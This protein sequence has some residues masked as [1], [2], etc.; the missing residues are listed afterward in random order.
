MNITIVNRVFRGS[1]AMPVDLKSICDSD[2]LKLGATEN[3]HVF[4]C[5]PKMLRIRRLP[6]GATVLLFNSGR[7]R[8][9][10]GAIE[11]VEAAQEWMEKLFPNF[12]ME[13]L[14]FLQTQ[15]CKFEVPFQCAN[16]V[17]KKY[18]DLIF[19]EPEI[20]T[21]AMKLI[22]WS[23]VHVNLFFSG[24][25]MIL[26]RKSYERAFE[27]KAWLLQILKEPVL[28]LLIVAAESAPAS[29]SSSYNDPLCMAI[30]ELVSML[31]HTHRKLGVGYF[32]SFPRKLIF[33]W[34]HRINSM[35]EKDTLIP[36]LCQ[37]MAR[38]YS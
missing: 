10:G 22:R 24:K 32:N 4:T 28:P 35:N 19:Y 14:P 7:F 37:Q 38:F 9:M 23:D 31:P 5:R 16:I 15:T 8:I 34:L 12:T 30:A 17:F 26:G 33:S 3:A 18:P 2:N 11:S 1:L 20:F 29:S 25:V 27:V 6:K 36:Q 13:T 21:A